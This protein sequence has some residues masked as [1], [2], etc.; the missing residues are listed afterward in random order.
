MT[1]MSVVPETC[2]HP[3]CTSAVETF[4]PLCERCYCMTHDELTPRRRH[5][6]LGEPADKDAD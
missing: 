4:C 3:G 5:A 2:E 1:E 6:C